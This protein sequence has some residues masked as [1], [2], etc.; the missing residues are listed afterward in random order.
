[1]NP[2]PIIFAIGLLLGSIAPA[3]AQKQWTLQECI[4]HAV[5]NNI[6]LKQSNIGVESQEVTLK[7]AKNE[8]LPS[9]N[10]SLGSNAYFGRGPG[11]DGTYEDQTQASASANLGADM[12]LYQGRSITNRIKQQ[13][14]NLKAAI[15]GYEAAKESLSLQIVAMY[16]QVLYSKESVAVAQTQVELADAFVVRS[17]SL[18]DGGK[19]AEGDYLESLASLSRD[20][21]T[22]VEA[23]SQLKIS[24]LNLSQALNLPYS[25]AFDVV[26]PQTDTQFTLQAKN[27]SDVYN[28]A[29]ENR[30]Q[31]K[32]TELRLESAI[33]DLKIARAGAMPRVGL[34]AGYSNSYHHTFVTDAVNTAFREQMRLNGSQSVGLS[35]SIPIFNKFSVKN[36]KIQAQYQI[37]NQELALSN[38]KLKLQKEIEQAY[39]NVII[40]EERYTASM[41]ALR[42]ANTAFEY[43]KIKA[44][45]GRSTIYDFNES[46]TN[47][48]RSESE[49]IRA[50]YE[51]MF[52]SKILNFYAGT[53]LY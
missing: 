15:E 20:Q 14:L 9:L 6:E 34:S 16:M 19:I 38:D 4:E 7:S 46:K 18:L 8:M 1:M 24:Q 28:Y 31:I 40:A 36:Q 5:A 12:T 27:S 2:K 30:P 13:E 52:N 25:E 29:V 50:K 49:L 37:D 21:M 23:Q 11:R 51:Y 53:P 42:A 22:L 3:S 39:Q 32:S 10:A 45:S 47:L 41:E 26:T 33:Y 48:I 44:D 43:T 17:K 35:V